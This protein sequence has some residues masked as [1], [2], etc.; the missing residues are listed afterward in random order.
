V[1]R[2]LPAFAEGLPIVFYVCK[3]DKDWTMEFL[4]EGFTALTG[5]KPEEVLENHRRSYNSLIHID[6]KNIVYEMVNYALKNDIPYNLEYRIITKDEKIKWVWEQGRVKGEQIS[7]LITDITPQKEKLILLEKQCTKQQKTI[8]DRTIDHITLLPN[9]QKLMEDLQKDTSSKLA[10][11]NLVNFEMINE[12]Y[13]YS[14]GDRALQEV[15]KWLVDQLR[16]THVFVY[17]GSED[18]FIL[19]GTDKI[20]NGKFVGLCQK[21]VEAVK[22][23][24]FDMESDSFS[25]KMRIGASLSKKYYMNAKRALKEARIHRQDIVVYDK[26]DDIKRKLINNIK[27]TKKLKDKNLHKKIVVYGQPIVDVKTK[28]VEKY[29][30]L[31][32]Y[33]DKDEIVAPNNFLDIAIDNNL[34]GDV[35]KIVVDKTVEYFSK[36]EGNFSINL[37]IEEIVDVNNIMY[38][39]HK[40]REHDLG[41]R[42]TFEILESDR[43]EKF[44]DLLKF[45]K[46]VKNNGVKIAIDDFGT[47]YSNFDYLMKMSV[48]VVKI[49][50]SIIE[51]LETSSVSRKL[52][53]LIVELSKE[54]GIKTIAE[55]V[56]NE[57]IFNIIKE[58]GIDYAQGYYFGKPFE[59]K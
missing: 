39:E 4:S 54:M 51:N 10:I 40:I 3:N 58:L 17:R 21:I 19:L 30:C 23:K 36:N 34:Y 38:I 6:D 8:Y 28:E 1:E 15:S 56:S 2:N 45:I 25:I 22:S 50:G 12:Y 16:K 32:R 13:G 49:D 42:L 43:V 57:N 24:K 53:S 33:K 44:D 48:D 11:I 26:N 55:Y 41:N 31:V 20:S 59:L 47:G 18:D 7:G 9:R 5:Y 46:R 27:W 35:T 29:E 37:S 14:M 52:V